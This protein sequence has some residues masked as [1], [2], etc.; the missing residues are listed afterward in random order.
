MIAYCGYIYFENEVCV[1][2]LHVDSRMKLSVI[3]F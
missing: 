2:F 1:Y 3:M